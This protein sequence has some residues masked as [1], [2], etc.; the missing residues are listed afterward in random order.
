MVN[1][2]GRVVPPPHP[3]HPSNAAS[4]NAARTE[5]DAPHARAIYEQDEVVRT[6]LIARGLEGIGHDEAAAQLD[7]TAQAVRKRWQRLRERLIERGVSDGLI[8][9]A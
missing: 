5:G 6:L 2:S 9:V 7:L 1:W 3:V 4:P 8:D